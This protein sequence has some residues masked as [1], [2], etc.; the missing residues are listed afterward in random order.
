MGET[1]PRGGLC[2]RRT[3]VLIGMMGAGKSAIGRALATRLGV[4]LKDSDETIVERA[5]MSI[6]EI[7]ERDGEAF[8]RD[9]ESRVI[10]SLLDG[11]PCVLSTGGGAWLSPAN[12]ATISAR[13]AVVWLKA[14]LD[15]LWSRV[16]HRDTRP[17]LRTPDPRATLA[18]LLAEREPHYAQAEFTLEVQKGWSVQDTTGAVLDLL[19][20]AG[21][22]LQEA[23]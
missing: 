20:E 9:K 19:T 22:V 8:F 18:A 16:R 14:D 6:A 15:L 1:M 2:L 3:V 7:F 23:A 12:R 11:P 13:A 4:P 21:V 10:R 5:R 17:L